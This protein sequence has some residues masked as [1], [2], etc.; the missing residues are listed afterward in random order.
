MSVP[1][2]KTAIARG[3]PLRPIPI[4]KYV[5][6]LLLQAL[7]AIPCLSQTIGDWTFN[8]TLIGTHGTNNIVSTADFSGGIPTRSY[9]GGTEY[10]GESGWPSGSVNTSDY[11]EFSISPN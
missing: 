2:L 8:N 1:I 7:I 6:S 10:F 9:N 4:G 11:M 5:Y 3:W